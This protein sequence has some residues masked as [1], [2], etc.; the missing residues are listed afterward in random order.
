VDCVDLKT[1]ALPSLETSGTQPK[2]QSDI[3]ED[4]KPDPHMSHSQDSWL[5]VS[6]YGPFP[7]TSLTLG[8]WLYK[9]F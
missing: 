3:P 4:T 6:I 1:K 5:A 9:F 8:M 7:D 2:M